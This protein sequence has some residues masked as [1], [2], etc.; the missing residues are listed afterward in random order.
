VDMHIEAAFIVAD[1]AML[2]FATYN[3]SKFIRA[4][5]KV[6][7]SVV[8]GTKE[9]ML[10]WAIL[11]VTAFIVTGSFKVVANT[12]KESKLESLNYIG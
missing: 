6:S 4:I 10:D 12:P 9:D 5:L 2:D 1:K 11:M 3:E 8:P 7:T